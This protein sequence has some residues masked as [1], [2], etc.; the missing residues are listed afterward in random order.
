MEL[1]TEARDGH[2]VGLT[3]YCL[4]AYA[5][6]FGAYDE[7]KDHFQQLYEIGERL[8]D[9]RLCAWSHYLQGYIARREGAYA[10][11]QE[12][13]ETSRSLFGDTWNIY[14]AA[15]DEHLGHLALA[16]KEMA[17]AQELYKQ[18]LSTHR[19]RNIPWSYTMIGVYWGIGPC[20]VRLGD[21]ALGLGK[22]GEARAHYAEAMQIGLRYGHPELTLDALTGWAQIFTKQVDPASWRQGTILAEM[23]ANHLDSSLEVKERAKKLLQA[24]QE[25]SDPG[26]FEAACAHSST[27]DL[28]TTAKEVLE[29]ITHG[30]APIAGTNPGGVQDA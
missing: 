8:D 5:I 22:E 7:A 27:C 28:A 9:R 16:Q 29:E 6:R 21:V 14:L 12:H 19:E 1:A 13:Y 3:L 24:L 25:L 4:G 26:A 10:Q 30:G 17:Q 2:R 18:A 11:S 15:Y 23:V 20:L